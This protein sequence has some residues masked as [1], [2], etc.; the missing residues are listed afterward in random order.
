MSRGITIHAG[1]NLV[2]ES[3]ITCG[4]L[5][6][7]PGDLRGRLIETRRNFYCP[8][9]ADHAVGRGSVCGSCVTQADVVA[10]II[11]AATPDGTQKPSHPL[12]SAEEHPDLYR[13]YPHEGD[14]TGTLCTACGCCCHCAEDGHC[15]GTPSCSAQ[16]CG[17]E[18]AS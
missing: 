12:K 17:C 9:I 16:S 5:F 2:T 11:N 15:D 18:D 10:R 7:F 8:M 1:L 6:A 13:R 4:V 14:C 3:C